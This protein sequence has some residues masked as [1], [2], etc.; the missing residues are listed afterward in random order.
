MLLCD[1]KQGFQ[2]SRGAF[3]ITNWLLN[4]KKGPSL[5]KKVQN[6]PKITFCSGRGL[7]SCDVGNHPLYFFINDPKL[8]FWS[9]KGFPEHK[10]PPPSTKVA[11]ICQKTFKITPKYHFPAVFAG[12]LPA[13][14]SIINHSI[15]NKLFWVRFL[16]NTRGFPDHKLD[17]QQQK[18]QTWPKNV[19][20]YPKS[21]LFW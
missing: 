14:T 3:K 21:L 17:P 8:G 18:G 13:V 19:N 4:H 16:G 1:P 9:K 2:G 15:F 6:S 12:N 11:R 7:N 20:D 5:V 10:V